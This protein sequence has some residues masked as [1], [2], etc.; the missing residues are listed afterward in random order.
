MIHVRPCQKCGKP[1]AP[2]EL[3]RCVA[4]R[5]PRGATKLEFEKMLRDMAEITVETLRSTLEEAGVVPK[6]ADG[7]RTI[8]W[9]NLT[10]TLAAT[11]GDILRPMVRGGGEGGVTSGGE[12]PY[13]PVVVT[14]CG[15]TRFMD[16]FHAAGWRETMAGRIVLSVGVAKHVE[17]DDGGHVG[18]ALGP[19][20]CAALDELHK[21]K[22][23]LSDEILVL[24]VGGY[25]GSSTRSEIEYAVAHGKRV[26][27]LEPESGR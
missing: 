1:L 10:D 25:V 26:R 2:N 21:R 27:W 11:F 18:E 4:C 19:E 14:L 6:K 23:D 12:S 8:A 16:E 20:V 13:R 17:T 5:D 7:F 3:D 22:I 9:P 15:S 24:N